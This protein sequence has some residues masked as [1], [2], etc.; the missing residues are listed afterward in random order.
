MNKVLVSAILAVC[1]GADMDLNPTTLQASAMLAVPLPETGWHLVEVDF[2][3]GVASMRLD[4]ADV[5]G[6]TTIPAFVPGRPY[7]YGFGAGTGGA[8]NR[9]EV[10][11][12]TVTFPT[13]RCI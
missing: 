7:F 8:V 9:H 11:N 6:A 5:V 12:F 10:R 3:N 1:M 4:S 2:Q 13:P